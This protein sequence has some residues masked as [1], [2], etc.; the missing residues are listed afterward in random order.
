MKKIQIKLDDELHRKL[1]STAA[2]EGKTLHDFIVEILK[3]F[4]EKKRG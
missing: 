3:N 4:M 1:K 2:L